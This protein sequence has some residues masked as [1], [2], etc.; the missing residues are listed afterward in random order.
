M[1]QHELVMEMI[2]ISM[3]E[4]QPKILSTHG[5]KKFMSRRTNYIENRAVP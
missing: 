3:T 4:G 2:A 1:N 5:I